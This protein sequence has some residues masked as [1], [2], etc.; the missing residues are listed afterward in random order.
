MAYLLAPLLGW[1][2]SGSLKF[3][4]NFLRYGREATSRI[5]NGGFPSTHTTIIATV[6]F[7][8]GF[9]EGFD[10]PIFALGVGVGFIV[11]ID[12]LGLRRAV[13]RHA[14]FLNRIGRAAVVEGPPVTLRESMG[15]NRLEVAGGLTVGIALA[16]A[17]SVVVGG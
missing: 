15:H 8:I 10:D 1:L 16:W 17:I 6:T 9:R 14:E 4:I 12:A 5:G 13:G 11:I 7:L 2:A 3:A